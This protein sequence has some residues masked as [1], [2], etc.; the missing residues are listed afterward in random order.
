MQNIN[1]FVLRQRRALTTSMAPSEGQMCQLLKLAQALRN[2]AIIIGDA[3]QGLV[4][5]FHRHDK[6]HPVPILSSNVVRGLTA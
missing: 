1:S 3:E 2:Q 5:R 4:E 6:G